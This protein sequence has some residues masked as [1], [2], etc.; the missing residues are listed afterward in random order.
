[1]VQFM[2][3]NRFREF[4]LHDNLALDFL[5]HLRVERA[6]SPHTLR[7]YRQA[8]G[9][10]V[11]WLRRH[12]SDPTGKDGPGVPWK[13]LKISVMREYLQSFLD[14]AAAD[15]RAALFRKLK[16]TPLKRASVLLHL[17]ALRSFHHF[18]M[19]KK[20]FA[21]NPLRGLLAPR[22]ERRLP[23]YLQESEVTRL[24][25][26]PLHLHRP[27]YAEWQKWRDKAILET[28]YSC[29]VRVHELAGLNDRDVDLVGDTIR[30]RGKGKR[31]RIVPLGRFA[32]EAI[33]AYR[34]LLKDD[35]DR[36]ALFVGRDGGRIST[37]GLQRIMK[38]YLRHAGLDLRLT[39]H[40]LRHSFATHLLNRGA[41]L[42]SVQQMLGH[43][44][45][46]TTQIYTH[47]SAERMKKVYD[48]AHPRAK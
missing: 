11:I 35:P 45:L 36:G 16:L 12:E 34:T 15:P 48:E 1:M 41:D 17:S 13:E 28:L 37:R 9:R 22:K 32:R 42:R 44:S 29:G 40:K 14:L 19:R 6:A 25:D 20:G 2:T 33:R 39:P 10:F 31:E 18:L 30:V 46:G 47:V 21:T 43:K 26:A 4:P 7:N 23:V 38:P 3:V 27:R 5:D 8:L 24:L